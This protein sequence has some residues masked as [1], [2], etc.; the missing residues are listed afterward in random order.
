MSDPVSATGIV[1]AVAIDFGASNTDVIARNGTVVHRWNVPSRGQP[2][3]T[4]VRE[5]LAHG[6]VMPSELS[7][8]AVTGGN[9]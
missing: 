7:W 8:I 1:H 6:L 9:R 2:D 5:V 4:R 3:E